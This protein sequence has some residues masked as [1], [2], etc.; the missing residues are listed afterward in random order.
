MINHRFFLVPRIENVS[1]TSDELSHIHVQ[2][3]NKGPS[4]IWA[5]N[6]RLRDR[7]KF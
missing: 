4:H 5:T 7:L 6:I 3:E 2:A 1:L